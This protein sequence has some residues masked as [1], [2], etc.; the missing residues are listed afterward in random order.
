MFVVEVISLRAQAYRLDVRAE[1]RSPGLSSWH[2]PCSSY[3][4]NSL[5][6][7]RRPSRGLQLYTT[8]LKCPDGPHSSRCRQAARHAQLRLSLWAREIVVE[9]CLRRLSNPR[10]RV[11][12]AGGVIGWSAMFSA[13]E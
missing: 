7:R 11:T 2:P 13:S 4:R 8:L 5:R 9:N 6:A 3:R 10:S 1:T 12:R